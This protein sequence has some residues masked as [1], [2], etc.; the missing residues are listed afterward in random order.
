MSLAQHHTAA[1]PHNHAERLLVLRA[2][3]S[4]ATFDDP[5][6]AALCAT[7]LAR[8][9]AKLAGTALP[10]VGVQ[11]ADILPRIVLLCAT[12]SPASDP[13]LRAGAIQCQRAMER[14]LGQ[15]PA[16]PSRRERW[17]VEGPQRA[18]ERTM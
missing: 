8:I 15:R 6:L 10:S 14:T 9:E 16:Q 13:I 3:L 17:E 4:E 1:V 7:V 5:A 12:L 11:V 2:L 18:I